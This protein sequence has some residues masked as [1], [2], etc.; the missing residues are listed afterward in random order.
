MGKVIF[1]T[2]IIVELFIINSFIQKHSQ[3]I[4]EEMFSWLD[5]SMGG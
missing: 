1:L 5:L 4:L 2:I 3:W